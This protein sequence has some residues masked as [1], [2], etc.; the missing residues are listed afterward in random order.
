M[1]LLFNGMA[2]GE[3][4]AWLARGRTA[5]LLPASAGLCLLLKPPLCCPVLVQ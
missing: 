2:K 4:G 3:L 5:R 1:G